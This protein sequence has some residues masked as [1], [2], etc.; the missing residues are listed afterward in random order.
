MRFIVFICL[1]VYSIEFFVGFVSHSFH[2]FGFSAITNACLKTNVK[3]TDE[4]DHCL[5]TMNLIHLC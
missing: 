3:T 2:L 1:F 4:R 5:K